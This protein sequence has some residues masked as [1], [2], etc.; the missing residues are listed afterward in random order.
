MKLTKQDLL[1][2]ALGA[3][4]AAAYP[5]GEALMRFS[6]EPIDDW[7]KWLGGLAAGIVAALMRYVATRAG[8]KH[9]EA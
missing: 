6:E 1:T 7:G 9:D 3:L 2:F 8:Q 5:L 4:A